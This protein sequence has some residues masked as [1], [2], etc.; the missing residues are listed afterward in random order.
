MIFR[1]TFFAL[2]TVGTALLNGSIP[3]S[4][5]GYLHAMGQALIAW[6]LASVG[7]LALTL[8]S[9]FFVRPLEVIKPRG[10]DLMDV[11][12]NDDAEDVL[13]RIKSDGYFLATASH[14]SG[15]LAK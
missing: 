11:P 15:A 12:I 1:C 5:S 3:H 9:S 6:G 10:D 8:V 7:F 2:G 4:R 14:E 13:G